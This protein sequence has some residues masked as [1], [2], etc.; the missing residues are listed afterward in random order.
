MANRV[1]TCNPFCP[2][3]STSPP[4]EPIRRWLGLFSP[5]PL[6]PMLGGW[7]LCNWWLWS[8][9]ASFS[10]LSHICPDTTSIPQSTLFLLY[11]IRNFNT[12]FI[13]FYYKNPFLVAYFHICILCIRNHIPILSLPHIY[14]F[15]QCIYII[16]TLW[17]LWFMA[18][19]SVTFSLITLL[20][21]SSIMLSII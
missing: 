18:L 1:L 20:F 19:T 12:I 4:I 3:S 6:W 13:L 17:S 15:H 10:L 9:P 8:T 14:E 5:V 7:V 2:G 11:F 21:L 16:H